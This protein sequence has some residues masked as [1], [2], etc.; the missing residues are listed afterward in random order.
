VIALGPFL[1]VTAARATIV[2]AVVLSAVLWVVGQGFGDV[3][4]GSGT[5]PNSGPLLMLV[6]AAFWPRR[7]RAPAAAVS[8]PGADLSRPLSLSG[9]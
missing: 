5:D 3:F 7:V 1:S 8:E 4:S 9:T 2:A 6:A